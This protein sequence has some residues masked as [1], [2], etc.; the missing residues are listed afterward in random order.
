MA[1]SFVI[2]QQGERVCACYDCE[3]EAV[4]CAKA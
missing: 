4:E 1:D 2:C 3:L